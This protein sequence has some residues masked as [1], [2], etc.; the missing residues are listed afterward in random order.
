[1]ALPG[2]EDLVEQEIND[3][4][5]DLKTHR[6]HGGITVH[7]PFS[8][9]L[10]MNTVLKT[11]TRI[12]LRVDEFRC[13]DFPKL[14]NRVIE[15]PWKNW[16]DPTSTL[17]VHA[18][19]RLSRLK[20]KTRI[21]ETC[22]EG[23][24]EY[25]S[26]LG[27]TADPK[28]QIAMYVRF[29]N[30][31]CVISLDTSGERLHKRGIREKIGEAPLRETIAAALLQLVAKTDPDAQN[32]EVVD[33]MMGSGTF[34]IEAAMR[35]RTVEREYA[36]GLFSSTSDEASLHAQRPKIIKLTG[37]ERDTK[38]INAAKDNLAQIKDGFD[39]QIIHRDFF[40]SPPL[41]KA[42]GAR[43]LLVNPPYGERLKVKEPLSEYY[44]KLFNEV[45]RVVQPSRACFLLPAKAVKG[46]FPLPLGWKVLEKRPIS[47]G[48]IPVV[49]FV[50]GQSEPG[51]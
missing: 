33:P 13:R 23:W 27:I 43:W 46:R 51:H 8:M 47:N 45:A 22:L 40:G 15:L 34:L 10:S 6:G 30:D 28:K 49:A 1:M 11:A 29:H 9:G 19:T 18:A 7:A 50:F 41:P 42:E 37:F 31:D 24:T 36:A 20:I 5:P 2:L 38:T 26:D 3:W 32:V 16:V 44:A 39:V 14:Y 12:L 48:G 35:D 25:Q 4:Y 17:T 21:E